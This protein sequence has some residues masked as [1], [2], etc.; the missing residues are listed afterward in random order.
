M[1]KFLGLALTVALMFGF[2]SCSEE[3]DN[4]INDGKT[5]DSAVQFSFTLPKS[6]FVTYSGIANEAEW[7]IK[8]LD[9]YAF[10]NDGKMVGTDK[11]AS[12]ADYTAT[13]ASGSTTTTVTMT[14]DW[15]TANLNKTITFYFVGNDPTH[16]AGNHIDVAANSTE[17]KFKEQLTKTLSNE[18]GSDG[19]VVNLEPDLLFSGV[20]S[21]VQMKSGTKI[22]ETVTMKRR[23]ARFDIVNPVPEKVAITEVV[24]LNAK[25]QAHIFST[26]VSN[27]DIPTGNLGKI[28]G[29]ATTDYDITGSES[30]ATSVFYL[31]PTNLTSTKIILKATVDGVNTLFEINS[32]IAI[33][34]NKRYKLVLN[35]STLDFTVETVDYEEGDVAGIES[36]TP[37]FCVYEIDDDKGIT[38]NMADK[39]I[40]LTN[41]ANGS[42]V[43]VY[44]MATTYASIQYRIDNNNDK[45]LK[46]SYIQPIGTELGY[47]YDELNNIHYGYR[48]CIPILYDQKVAGETINAQLV[49]TDKNKP[50][51]EIVFNIIKN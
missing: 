6:S 16:M 42:Y 30:I 17:A 8:S 48:K 25:K 35:E 34:A 43:E 24:V 13:T 4:G 36:V 50:G 49:I 29:P 15:V 45:V 19:L 10:D 26:A 31:Y 41:E 23:E 12:G 7:A 5:S 22:K 20:S 37:E 11:L 14:A 27:V 44:V 2:T 47:A 51:E 38:H 32:N 18:L 40:N 1:K 3:I 21:P 46:V 28:N 33:D 39:T 9:I